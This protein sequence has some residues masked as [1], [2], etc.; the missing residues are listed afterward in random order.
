MRTIAQLFGRSPFGPLQAHMV[1][2]VTCVEMLSPVLEAFIQGDGKTVLESAKVISTAEH[3]ADIL[4]ADIRN[5]L[6]KSLFLPVDRDNLLDILATQDSLA[7]KVEDVA[8]LLTLKQMQTPDW[9]VD[10]LRAFCAKNL[11]AFEGVRLI[12]D[13]IDELLEYA[14]GG[15]EAEKVKSMIDKVSTLEYEA[16][17]LGHDLLRKLYQ[18]DS[19]LTYAQFDIY[20]RLCKELAQ[21][22][23]Y[24]EDLANLVRMTLERK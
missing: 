20:Q 6:P 3:A 14:F 2:V 24:S 10:D 21:I 23:N 11:E 13:Q 15:A 8:I 17:L 12:I 22:S 1:K 5:H 7:D 16:D 19:D 18:H 4:K 9:L